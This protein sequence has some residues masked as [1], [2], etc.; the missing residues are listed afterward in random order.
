MPAASYGLSAYYLIAPA[1]AS[2]NLARYDGVRYG[3]RVDAPTTAEMNAATRT[4]GFGDEVKRRIMLG[5]Y[6]LSAGYYDAYYGKALKVRTLIVR[7][8]EAAYEHF[9]LLLVA[10]LADDGVPLRRQ[11]RRPAGDVPQ[12][13]LHH[14]DQ[15]GRPPG[16]ER[17][18][19]AAAPTACP[20]ASSCSPPPSAR[21][22]CSG[23]PPWSRPPPRHSRR[24]T[25]ERQPHPRAHRGRALHR[26]QRDHGRRVGDRRRPRG[27]LRAGHRHQALLQLPEHVRR[28]AQHQRVPGVP[29]PAR[30][31]AGAEPPGGRAGHAPRPGPQL[32]RRAV[33]V[34]PEELLLPGH[35]EGLPGHPVRPAHQRRRLA[36]PPRRHPRRHRAGPHRGG[37]RQEHPR[38]WQ[39]PHPRRRLLPRRLQPGRRP[40]GRDRRPPPHPPPRAGQGLRRRAARH[41]AGHRGLRRQD[42]GGLAARR[43]QRVGAPGRRPRARQA[44][45]GQEPQLAALAR[46]G[47]RV[48]GP[49]PGRPA[50]DRRAREAG[51]PSLGRGCRP[52]P[53][54]P[55]EGGGG[56]LPLLPGAR[57]GAARPR[58]PSG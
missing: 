58:R 46:A 31:A 13:H 19:S 4:A 54:G 12:R 50:G 47:H 40:A 10:D 37:H 48:R 42:G 24:P 30:L 49:P 11:D 32:P 44:V 14:P 43:R 8:F 53:P 56:G 3:M 45:R 7:D 52:H 41:P 22:P 17:S 16:D 18:P 55:V 15:P 28:R 2:S 39:R 38:R 33:G 23:P 20:S 21:P 9:D 6:A 27:P 29:R 34:R 5:T 26:H 57:P 1:E 35:A 36:R 51:D 25:H